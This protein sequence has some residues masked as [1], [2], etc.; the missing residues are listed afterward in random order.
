MWWLSKFSLLVTEKC[1]RN[2]KSSGRKTLHVM[3]PS[4]LGR[5]CASPQQSSR[6]TKD[7]RECRSALALPAVPL[8]YGL[9]SFGAR[10]VE[11]GIC[12]QPWFSSSRLGPS[13]PTP[14]LFLITQLFQMPPSGGWQHPEFMLEYV[15]LRFLDLL[16]RGSSFL[17]GTTM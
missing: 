10:H 7:M 3:S 6:G 4:G 17:S 11:N 16:H 8:K 5:A 14:R 1:E 15:S 12:F 9:Q 13:K 2:S